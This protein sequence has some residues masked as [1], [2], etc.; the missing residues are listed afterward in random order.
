[1]EFHENGGNLYFHYDFRR[2]SRCLFKTLHSRFLLK[3]FLL[4]KN[5]IGNQSSQSGERSSDQHES[6]V[7]TIHKHLNHGV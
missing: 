5:F 7:F 1:M 4:F 2:N 6:P 3:V